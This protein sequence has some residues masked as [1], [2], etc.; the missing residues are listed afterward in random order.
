VCAIQLPA[1]LA[2]VLILMRG[3][4]SAHPVVFWLVIVLAVL[5]CWF[6]S[7]ERRGKRA[8]GTKSERVSMVIELVGNL[9]VASSWIASIVGIIIAFV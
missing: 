7:V 6:W 2:V 1:L 8:S 5:A 4:Y 9:V 3:R